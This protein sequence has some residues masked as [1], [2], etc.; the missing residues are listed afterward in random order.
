M[1]HQ[2]KT[3][4]FASQRDSVWV[5]DGKYSNGYRNFA[6]EVRTPDG[7]SHYLRPKVI[8][9]W[10]KNIPH[11][12]EISAGK[13]Y[14]LPGWTEESGT[15]SLKELGLDLTQPGVYSI[16]GVYLENGGHDKDRDVERT[17]WGGNIATNTVTVKA[18]A[19]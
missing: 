13:P 14:V 11:P 2:V 10:D 8:D 6:F 18:T 1:V 9:N 12:V 17:L 3:G 16:T 19:K 4:Q 5:W 7:E 15:K